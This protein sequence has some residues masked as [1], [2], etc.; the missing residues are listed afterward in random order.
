MGMM[1]IRRLFPFLY[2]WLPVYVGGSIS[3]WPQFG[4]LVVYN[5]CEYISGMEP[6][7]F[8]RWQLELYHL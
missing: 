7:S 3:D 1:D 2:L 8:W 5:Q 6:M 4:L